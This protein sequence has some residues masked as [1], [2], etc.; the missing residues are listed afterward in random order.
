MERDPESA[1]LVRALL[2]FGRG[3]GLTVTAEGVERPGQA[4]ALMEQGCEQAQGFL[5]SKALSTSDAL[6]LLQSRDSSDR[7]VQA[8]HAAG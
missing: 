6:D 1:L 5:Y 3:L 4:Q 8:E 7:A 2:G